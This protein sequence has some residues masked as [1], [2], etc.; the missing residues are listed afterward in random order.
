M[1]TRSPGYH[2]DV[3]QSRD[4]PNPNLR[5]G[6]EKWNR[7]GLTLSGFRFFERLCN[8]KQTSTRRQFLARTLAAGSGALAIPA[9]FSGGFLGAA[10][11]LL[12][13][14]KG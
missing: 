6:T 3:S 11:P 9:V 2:H 12:E 8:M 1:K 5:R 4:R 14:L 10:L 13:L 7:H